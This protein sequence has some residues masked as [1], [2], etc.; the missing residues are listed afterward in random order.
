MQ[1]SVTTDYAIRIIVFLDVEGKGTARTADEISK[2]MH[3]PKGYLAKI[4]KK[5]KNGNLIDSVMGQKGGYY[6]VKD[7]KEITLLQ[8]MENIEKTMFINRCLEPDEYCNRAAAHSCQIRRYYQEVQEEIREKYFNISIE[9]LI[10]RYPDS[11]LGLLCDADG[12]F[13]EG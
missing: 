3:I 10:H 2:A 7:K 9:E 13:A 8:I 11:G 12:E 6:L 4:L 5:L 1:I